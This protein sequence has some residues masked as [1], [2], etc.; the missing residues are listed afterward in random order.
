A[1]PPTGVAAL[2]EPAVSCGY[3]RHQ[4]EGLRRLAAALRQLVDRRQSGFV[5][6]FASRAEEARGGAVSLPRRQA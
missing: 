4:L 1:F 2:A 6:A 5:A 3:L